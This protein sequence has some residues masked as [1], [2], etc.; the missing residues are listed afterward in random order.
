[1]ACIEI[2]A[3]TSGTILGSYD[4]QGNCE[5]DC[6][7]CCR[8]SCNYDIDSIH[9]GY[10]EWTTGYYLGSP[11]DCDACWGQYN[12]QVPYPSNSFQLY[13]QDGFG[14]PYSFWKAGYPATDCGGLLVSKTSNYNSDFGNHCG[15]DNCDWALHDKVAVYEDGQMF[16]VSYFICTEGGWVDK[17]S[18]ALNPYLDNIGSLFSSAGTVPYSSGGYADPSAMCCYETY[19]GPALTYNALDY[20]LKTSWRQSFSCVYWTGASPAGNCAGDTEQGCCMLYSA[21]SQTVQCLCADAAPSGYSYGACVTTTY[22][23]EASCDKGTPPA[24]WDQTLPTTTGEPF[25]YTCTDVQM[26]FCPPIESQCGGLYFWRS[27][28]L[29]CTGNDCEAQMNASDSSETP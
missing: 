28:K 1:M 11:S 20:D 19:N 16:K 3:Y 18:E 17:T 4:D 10:S 15:L 7:I 25:N 27:G 21:N 13:T 29:S 12:T 14:N 26:Q 23:Q 9:S 6:G 24:G 8:M 22:G 2:A 5:Q